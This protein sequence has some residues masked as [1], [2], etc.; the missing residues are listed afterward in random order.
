MGIRRVRTRDIQDLREVR[1]VLALSRRRRVII[2][3]SRLYRRDGERISL[4]ATGL[5]S[6]REHIPG[7][8]RT[9]DEDRRNH[10]ELG[11]MSNASNAKLRTFL[12]VRREAAR[13]HGERPSASAAR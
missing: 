2:R 3:R 1:Q 8:D 4:S 5:R 9:D 13:F 7:D 11:C 12:I 6:E 10:L